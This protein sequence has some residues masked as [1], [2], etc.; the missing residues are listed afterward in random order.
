ML[1]EIFT[2]GSCRGNPGPGGWAWIMMDK[3]GAA[4]L[5]KEYDN[6]NPTTNNR[7]ELKAMISALGIAESQ[8]KDNFIIW[9]DSAYVVNACNDWVWKWAANGWRNS[10]NQPVENI[11]LMREIYRFMTIPWFNA[12]VKKCDGHHGIIGNE[13]ADKVATG[14]WRDY[15]DLLETYDIED[16]SDAMA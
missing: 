11:D 4:V 14:N 15:V 9:S 7:M 13:L 12:T 10:K 3:A 8:P 1:Y 5:N 16:R 2:D 6:E